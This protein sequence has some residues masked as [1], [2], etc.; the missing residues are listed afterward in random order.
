MTRF[1]QVWLAALVVKTAF[2][3]W[4]PFSNDETYYWVWGHHPQ[5]SYYDH[6][7][8]VGW[9]F[10]LGTFLENIGNGARLPGVWLGHLSLLI[11]SKILEP[12]IDDRRRVFWLLFMLMSPFFGAG[13]LV[14]TPDVP[15]VFFWSL[16][17]WIFI[18]LLKEPRPSLYAALGVSLGLAFCSKYMTVLFVPIAIA[19]IAWSR[20]WKSVRW[21]YVPVT[22]VLGLA[23]CFPVLY[24]NATHD[25][26]S[27]RFQLE[28]GLKSETWSAVWPLE[29]IGG[30]ILILFPTNVWLAT[31]RREP[32][33]ARFLVLFGWLP[34]AF[35]FYTSF[36][37]HVEGNWPIMAHPALLALAFINAP[38]S[39]MLRRTVL[40]WGAVTLLVFTEVVHHWV[41][42]DP[43]KLKTSE[44][45]RFDKF[46]PLTV[47]D[48]TAFFGSYQMASAV[49]YKT[50]RQYYKIGGMNRRDFYDFMPQSYPEHGHLLIVHESGMPLPTWLWEKQFSRSPAITI[51]SV[52]EMLEAKRAKDPGR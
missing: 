9:I 40:F 44:F 15:L 11:W 47:G 48:K 41:P 30:Q 32:K 52:Y 21:A 27:F 37:A 2:A 51:D 7:P 31:R 20:S 18:R 23:F 12:F 36:K 17:L 33:E 35:F 38:D 49:S 22:I 13:S 34:I 8:M 28:H 5:W 16:S 25:W 46:I 43:A 19:W 50:R 24:W 14:I 39:K 4:L 42:V 6:P 26:A 1:F 45:T 29:Y 3:I 10:W